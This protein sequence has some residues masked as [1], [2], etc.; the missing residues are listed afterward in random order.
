MSTVIP[1]E[2][3]TDEWS[4]SMTAAHQTDDVPMVEA[5]PRLLDAYEEGEDTVQK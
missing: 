2:E 4:V 1:D 3:K 5:T